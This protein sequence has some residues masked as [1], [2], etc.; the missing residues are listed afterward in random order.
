M[1]NKMEKPQMI[2]TL[3]EKG[4]SLRDEL[5]KLE[6]EFNKKKEDYLKI[7]GALEALYELEE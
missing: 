2:E 7:Q 5:I 6:Q 1:E 3:M 4:N